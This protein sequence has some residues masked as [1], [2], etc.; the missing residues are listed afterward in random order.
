M[1]FWLSA[2]PTPART[3]AQRLATAIEDE[4]T[5]QP[6]APVAGQRPAIEKV[7]PDAPGRAAASS[8][9][10]A[11]TSISTSHSGRASAET[12]SPVDTGNTPFS[13]APTV[14]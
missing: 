10:T 4:V 2:V 8:G 5:A 3:K 9:I 12:T 1:T 6:S 7:M 13:H 14:R 11:T